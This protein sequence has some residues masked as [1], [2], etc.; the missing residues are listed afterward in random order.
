MD[1]RKS[2]PVLGKTYHVGEDFTDIVDGLRAID[3]VIHFLDFDCGDRLGHALVLGVDPEEWYK[4]KRYSISVNIQDY[5]DNLAWLYHAINHFSITGFDSLKVRIVKDF[6]YRFRIV[7]RNSIN[8]ENIKQL[9]KRARSGVYEHTNEDHDRYHEHT[10]H[11]DI[12]DYYR[13]WTLRGDDP[14]CYIKGFFEKPIGYRTMVP[15]ERC[16]VNANFPQS[17]DDRYVPEYSL[18]TYLYHFDAHV[19]KEGS[20]EIVV[21]I[22]DDYVKAVKCVQLKMRERIARRGISVETNPTSNVLIG[23]FREYE[24]HPILTFYNR[25]LPVTEDEESECAQLQISINTD[26]SGVFYTDLETEYA[27]MARAT[28]QIEDQDGHIRFKKNDVYTWLD[29]IRIMGNEQSF[30]NSD[31]DS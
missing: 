5:L 1:E 18:L 24:K 6:E 3:E 30:R 17:Y 12:M 10:C 11:F 7:Y 4:Q 21:E 16:K 22:S 20:R 2:L 31:T 14:S 25:G 23:T 28:E 8:D 19:R 15:E 13:S 26:D 9:M 27:L 29:N